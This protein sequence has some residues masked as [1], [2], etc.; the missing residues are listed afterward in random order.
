MFANIHFRVWGNVITVTLQNIAL[1]IDAL[2]FQFTVVM[3][4]NHVKRSQYS[5]LIKRNPSHRFAS[6]PLTS[7]SRGLD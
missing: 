7:F 4:Y 3:Q 2:Q 5:V 6:N 1:D